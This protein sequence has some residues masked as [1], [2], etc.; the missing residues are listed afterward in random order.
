MAMPQAAM[1]P[2]TSVKQPSKKPL[3]KRI[4]KSMRQFPMLYLGGLIVL[5]LIVC[6]FFAPIIAHYP[7]A[8]VFQDGI[9][10]EGTPVAPNHQFIWGTDEV[11]RDVYSRVIYGSRVSLTVGFFAMIISLVIGTTLGLLAGYFGGIVDL[12][13][14]RFTDTVLAFPFLLFTMALVAILSPSE[15]NVLIAIGVLSW[16]TMARVVRG[17]VLSVREFE[18]VQAERA[19]GASTVRI[20]FRVILPNILGPVLVLAALSVGFNIILEAGLSY[21][22]IGIQQPVPSWGNMINEG[23]QNYQFAPWMMWAPGIALVIAVLGFNLLGDGLR[24]V[25]DPQNVTR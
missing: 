11:G 15:K 21:L 2:Q 19:I 16:G 20:L 25:L 7:Y 17:E 13:V 4:W 14:M 10:S 3:M 12:I 1:E 8:K 9:S 6:A 5:A 18:Y 24:D 23:L 22:G